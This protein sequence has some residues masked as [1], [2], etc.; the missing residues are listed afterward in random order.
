MKKD[1]PKIKQRIALIILLGFIASV[2]VSVLG[3]I[4]FM[5]DYS[6]EIPTYS[7][8]LM[9]A[10]ELASALLVCTFVM[11]SVK[12]ADDREVIPSAGFGIFAISTGL[13]MVTSFE[14][15][16]HQNEIESLEVTFHMYL[17][18]SFLFIPGLFMVATYTGFPKWLHYLTMT[19][20][21]P[22]LITYTLFLMGE[23]DLHV[24]D[25][26][27]TVSWVL[28][29]IVQILWGVRVWKNRHV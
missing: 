3:S 8:N 22:Y 19:A 6:T 7:D 16:G 9:I 24:L 4:I 20:T 15:I 26:I 18:S 17:G 25:P 1:H 27:S 23:R 10:G 13:I 12:L 14:M 28:M 11:L 21:I 5:P 29:N 2:A